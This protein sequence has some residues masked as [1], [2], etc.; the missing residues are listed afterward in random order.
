MGATTKAKPFLLVPLLAGLAPLSA[1]GVRTVDPE[2]S[3][4]TVNVGKTGLL[5]ALGDTH[6]VRAPITSGSIHEGDPPSVEITV[7]ARRMTVLDPD[8]KPDKRDEVQ[9]RMLGPEVLDVDRYKEI[10]FRSTAVRPKGESRWRV[11]GVL[12]LRDRGVPVS[13]DVESVKDVFRGKATISQKAYGIKPI[14]AGGG[15]VKVKDELEVVFEIAT[16]P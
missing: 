3:S 1:A 7:D 9:K 10:R 15:T 14:S 4:L 8:L 5:S 12:T 2:R 6:T 11:E 13:F 16:K